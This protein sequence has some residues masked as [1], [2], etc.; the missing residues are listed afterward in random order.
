MHIKPQLLKKSI[1]KYNNIDDIDL[2]TSLTLAAEVENTLLI[3][4]TSL[5]EKK[6]M[7]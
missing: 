1:Q 6:C 4:N 3:E 5:K 7:N 2:E